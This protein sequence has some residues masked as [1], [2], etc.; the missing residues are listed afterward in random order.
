[1]SSGELLQ[2]IQFLFVMIAAIIFVYHLVKGF[3]YFSAV[4]SKVFIY[5]SNKNA[6]LY[7]RSLSVL[8]YECFHKLQIWR[9]YRFS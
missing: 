7:M 6:L 5:S 1:M 9:Y 2:A 4:V 3:K 8:D